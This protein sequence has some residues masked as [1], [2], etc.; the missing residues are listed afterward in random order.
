[1]SIHPETAAHLG[2]ADG[3]AIFIENRGGATGPKAIRSRDRSRVVSAG[4]GWW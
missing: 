2:V 4:Y 3:D 1:V